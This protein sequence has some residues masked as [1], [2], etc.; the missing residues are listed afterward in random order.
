MPYNSL[1]GITF[2]NS[3]LVAGKKIFASAWTTKLDQ[4]ESWI[5]DEVI[6]KCVTNTDA[7][8]ISG[9]KTFSGGISMGG[10]AKIDSVVDP[11][12]DQDAATKKYVDDKISNREY[13][14]GWFACTAGG[15]YTLTHGLGTDALTATVLFKDSSGNIHQQELVY[16][17][18]GSV[19]DEFGAQ[20]KAITSTQVTVQAGNEAAGWYLSSTGDFGNE[21]SGQYRVLIQAIGI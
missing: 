20:V 6:A 8:T 9:K 18:E 5:T 10:L 19:K 14:S 17:Y 2:N 21:T 1:N 13:D 11:E 12:A 4:I 7:Q 15:T 16:L 3:D